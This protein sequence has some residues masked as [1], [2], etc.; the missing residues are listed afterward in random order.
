MDLIS[1]QMLGIY[2]HAQAMNQVPDS[3]E[4]GIDA[5]NCIKRDAARLST[6]ACND[7]GDVKIFGVDVVPNPT[8]ANYRVKLLC[9][10]WTAG[11]FTIGSE[12]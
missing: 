3:W 9:G 10:E 5:Y 11:A 1:D 8:M 2:D 7:S 12:E 6:F 4:V